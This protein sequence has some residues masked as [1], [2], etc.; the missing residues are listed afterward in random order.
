MRWIPVLLLV[1]LGGVFAASRARGDDASSTEPAVLKQRLDA[2]D[3]EVSYLLA[4]E[5]A[6][7][8]YVTKNQDRARAL[9]RGI[10]QVRAQGF[11]GGAISSTSRETLLATFEAV[12]R[13]LQKEVP[14]MTAEQGRALE[15]I[16][17][18]QKK[19]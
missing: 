5:R 2:L 12:A 16:Q 4:R 15:Q 18:L 11:T 10:A 3:F 17:R 9:E 14:V 13:D 6:L 8:D 1:A 7:T 19:H